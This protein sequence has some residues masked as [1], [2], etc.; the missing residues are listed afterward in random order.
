MS[1]NNNNTNQEE[2]NSEADNYCSTFEET[3]LTEDSLLKIQN[4]Q[5]DQVPLAARITLKKILNNE[6]LLIIGDSTMGVTQTVLIGLIDQ[7]DCNKKETQ[8][9][10][11]LPTRAYVLMNSDFLDKYLDNNITVTSIMGGSRMQPQIEDLKKKPHIVLSTPGRLMQFLLDGNLSTEHVKGLALFDFQRMFDM[12]FSPQIDEINNYLPKNNSIQKIATT[13]S[14]QSGTCDNILVPIS[15]LKI[16]D[17]NENNVKQEKTFYYKLIENE[18]KRQESLINLLEKIKNE[19]IIIFTNTSK[20]NTNVYQE[21]QGN[22]FSVTYIN[23]SMT[24]RVRSTNITSF[25][26]NRTNILIVTDV[27]SRGIKFTSVSYLINYDLANSQR[28]LFHRAT[29]IN[30]LHTISFVTGDEKQLYLTMINDI[31]QTT[32]ELPENFSNK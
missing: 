23:G 1:Q 25:E 4:Y 6:D 20:T 9:I 7:I 16:I 18:N 22:S 10:V 19:R 32:T 27:A 2:K 12:G 29:K 28:N 17:L 31:K 30:P 15:S 13:E 14:F 8:L 11:I 21:L 3:G 24:Q 5:F 26:Q